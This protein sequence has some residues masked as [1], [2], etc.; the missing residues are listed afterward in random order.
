M[1]SYCQTKKQIVGISLISG[2]SIIVLSFCIYGLL[3]RGQ[4][5]AQDLELPLSPVMFE[6]GKIFE[7]I[8]GFIIICSIF[9]SAISTGYSFL[10]NVSKNEKAYHRNLILISIIGILVSNFGFS[11][12][13][14]ILYPLFGI[15]G[16]IQ[17]IMLFSKK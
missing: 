4:F 11:N 16:F 12:L 17:I 5:F 9:T 13:V 10:Q 7:Y 15:L 2:V 8:Y 1:K 14:Q 6:F 3:L